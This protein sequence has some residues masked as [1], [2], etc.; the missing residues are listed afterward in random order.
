MQNPVPEGVDCNFSWFIRFMEHVSL[1]M[2]LDKACASML[3]IQKG[4]L[5]LIDV[6][7]GALTIERR[8]RASVGDG[9]YEAT[10]DLTACLRGI[11]YAG[12]FTSNLLQFLTERLHIPVDLLESLHVNTGIALSAGD[13]ITYRV[14]D[15]DK[16]FLEPPNRSCYDYEFNDPVMCLGKYR[17]SEEIVFVRSDDQYRQL[18]VSGIRQAVSSHRT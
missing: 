13:T 17:F 1:L 18:R 3:T 8:F 16:Q 7:S 4:R 10:I 11:L 2:G 9:V 12:P 15:S 14:R 5:G 6:Y